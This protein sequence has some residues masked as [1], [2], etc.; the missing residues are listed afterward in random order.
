[1]AVFRVVVAGRKLVGTLCVDSTDPSRKVH[2]CMQHS[3]IAFP[4]C[5]AFFFEIRTLL[6]KWPD[7]EPD[8]PI[9]CSGS[10][11]TR[12]CQIASMMTLM[13]RKVAS[14]GGIGFTPLTFLS[15]T[16]ACV[17]WWGWGVWG[18]CRVCHLGTHDTI[19]M[20]RTKYEEDAKSKTRYGSRTFTWKIVYVL[21][22]SELCAP[23]PACNQASKLVSQNTQVPKQA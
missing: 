19:T 11:T 22:L 7:I 23:R 10:D 17:T 12:V 13:T 18:R 15:H 14:L 1:M 20:T 6:V 2:A 5:S 21:V 16:C 4:P 8:L 9:K 3:N